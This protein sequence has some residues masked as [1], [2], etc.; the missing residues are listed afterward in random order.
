MTI[1][2]ELLPSKPT[3]KACDLHLCAKNVGVPS[4][5]L[6]TSLPPKST[7]PVVIVLG[8]NPG[9]QEDRANECWI[10]PSGQ[11]LTGPYLQGSGII[12]T[13]TV[14]LCNIARCVSPG[15]TP[16][17]LHYRTCI[18]NTL[19]DINTILDFHSPAK[20]RAILCAGADPLRYFSKTFQKKHMYQ[21]EGFKSQGMLI[22]SLPRTHLFSTFHP[23]AVLRE[24]GLIHPVS[25]HMAL[26]FAFLTG[27]L[28]KPSL[29]TIVPA[30][31]PRNPM[32][33]KLE[34]DYN[35]DAFRRGT[36]NG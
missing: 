9:N 27:K 23:A 1:S 29:P 36:I 34:A 24:P 6:P 26:L 21:T 2:L 12:D 19:S 11:L 4:R 20:S 28:A 3:C 15:G 14:Y 5:H 8:M 25:D 30:F 18:G 7:N 13:A 32:H 17:P 10:G 35:N 31:Y 16:K 22:P 33:D